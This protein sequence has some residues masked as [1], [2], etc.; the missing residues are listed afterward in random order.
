MLV[1]RP[2]ISKRSIIAA[3][4]PDHPGQRESAFRTLEKHGILTDGI[5]VDLRSKATGRLAGRI[6]L[7]CSLNRDAARLYRHGK[8]E[9]AERLV[10]QARA[11]EANRFT[12]E[13]AAAM[14]SFAD[15][16]E[17]AS[18]EELSV[19]ELN[20]ASVEP[21]LTLIE[22]VAKLVNEARESATGDLHEIQ[23]RFLGR[24]SNVDEE[25]SFLQSQDGRRLQVLTKGLQAMGLAQEG[26]PVMA[27]LDTIAPD[28]QL[29]LTEPAIDVKSETKFPFGQRRAVVDDRGWAQIQAALGRVHPTKSTN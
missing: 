24:V 26:S 29:T 21:L 1:E 12:K 28:R 27:L 8:N 11:I 5:Q 15:P 9:A 2:L 16:R 23:I 6:H 25:F 10:K 13:L 20:A 3:F 17:D 22:K 7:Y 18:E 4:D 14:G 19:T